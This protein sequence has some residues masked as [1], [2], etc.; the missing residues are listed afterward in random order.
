MT[1][2]HASPAAAVV[3]AP[4]GSHAH[5]AVEPV[6]YPESDGKPLGETLAH[7]HEILYLLTALE[8]FYA[9]DPMVFVAADLF[10]YYVEGNPRKRVAPDVFV[11]RGVRSF[12]RRTYRVWEEGRAPEVAF[13]IT[14]RSSRREDTVMKRELYASLGVREYFLFDP[15]GEY[16]QPRLQGYRLIDGGY[17]S[18]TPGED[19]GLHSDVLGLDLRLRDDRLRLWDPAQEQWLRTPAEEAAARQAAEQQVQSLRAEI[20]RLR[21]G[22]NA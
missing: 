17:R 8:N 15:L 16:L 14:S 4:A 6:T 19:G 20:A 5:Q 1:P 3:E 9:R 11:V 13:E 22:T 2:L 10:V 21:A 7:I 18:M 12:E